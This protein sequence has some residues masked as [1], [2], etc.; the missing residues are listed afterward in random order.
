MTDVLNT[1]LLVAST[2][3]GMW[4]NYMLWL[5]GVWKATNTKTWEE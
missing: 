2:S 1:Y 3:V 5:D 4:H